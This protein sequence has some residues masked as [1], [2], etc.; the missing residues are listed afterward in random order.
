MRRPFHQ[1]IRFVFLLGLAP[2]L[3]SAAP[4]SSP[5]DLIR[6]GNDVFEKSEYE[7]ALKLYQDAQERGT[8]PGLIAFN[9]ATVYWHKR[10]YR[11]AENHYRM[12]LDDAA[13]PKER[14]SRSFFNLGN[15]LVKQADPRDHRLLR[16][17]IQ[18]YE[19]CIDQTEDADLRKNAR[20]NL[21]IAKILWNKAR[22]TSPNPPSPNSNEPPETPRHNEP[23]KP[24]LDKEKKPGNNDDG[25]DHKK[26]DQK[27]KIDQG[28]EKTENIDPD[29]KEQPTPGPGRVPVIPDT[30]KLERQTAEDTRAALRAAELRLKSIRERLRQQAATSENSGGKN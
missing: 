12:A 25:K 2:L 24:D 26:N 4:N 5:D 28:T 27:K 11:Q 30:D 13:A 29:K 22:R 1:R 8:D 3:V 20:H 15:C 19:Y 9:A 21:E 23:K 6:E 18:Y 17:A 7:A 16:E 10:E 14:R